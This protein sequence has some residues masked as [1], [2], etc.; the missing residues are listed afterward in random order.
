[1][2][3]VGSDRLTQSPAFG[4]GSYQYTKAKP[5]CNLHIGTKKKEVGS[6]L[7]S[8][9]KYPSI[10]F[11]SAIM[12]ILR[13]KMHISGSTAGGIWA[14]ALARTLMQTLVSRNENNAT[15]VMAR[16]SNAVNYKH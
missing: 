14:V 3:K 2:T 11:I 13:Y 16:T 10:I 15:A 9:R 7:A 12:A 8:T 4:F 1:M 6:T 5:P